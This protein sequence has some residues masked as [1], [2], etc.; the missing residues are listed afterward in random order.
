M[1]Y[2]TA[3]SVYRASPTGAGAWTIGA[4]SGTLT[5]VADLTVDLASVTQPAT[6][7]VTLPA[8]PTPDPDPDPE[9]E[10]RPTR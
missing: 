3:A 10:E 8:P 9:P 1:P 6:V 7:N 2:V 5:A 4:T